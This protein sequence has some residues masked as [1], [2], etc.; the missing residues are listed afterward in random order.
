MKKV[1]ITGASGFIGSFLVEEALNRNQEVYA[2]IRSTSSKEYLTDSRIKF[3]ELDFS[4][5]DS[6]KNTLSKYSAFDYIIHNAGTTKAYKK[7][8]Y[9]I[10][11]FNYT[12]NFI[13]AL[14]SVNKVPA[15]FVYISSLAAYGPG[16]ATILNTVKSTDTPQPVTAYGKSKLESERYLFSLPQFPFIIIRPTAV[17]GPREKDLLTMFKMIN[18]H[19]ELFVGFKKQHLTFVYVK[20]LVKA[21]LLAAESDI[22]HKGYFVSDGNC[23][24]SAMF[25]DAIKR[26]LNKKTIRI[27]LPVFFVRMIATIAESTKYITGKQSVLNIE[28]INELAAVNWKCDMQTT[29]DDLKYAPEYDLNK[30]IRETIEGYKKAKWL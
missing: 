25:G 18:K 1:L 4:D 9:L 21:I 7:E 8:D 2:G 13:E 29:I 16:D 17:Y 22:T 10:G 27:K 14:I 6:L 20:D 5:I 24:D 23:Y 11:N 12:R 3:I 19:V 30:G 28:K 26:E 15:K